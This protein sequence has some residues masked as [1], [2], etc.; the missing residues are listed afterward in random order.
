MIWAMSSSTYGFVLTMSTRSSRSTGSPWGERNLVPRMRAIPRLEAMMTRGDS[1][2]S[3][4]RLRNEKHSMSNM[5][6]SSMNR[7]YHCISSTLLNQI[8]HHTPALA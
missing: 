7:T 4:A 3:N 5:C 2:F 8:R 6:T 1:S